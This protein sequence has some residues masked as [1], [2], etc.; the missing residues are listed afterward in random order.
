MEVL[1]TIVVFIITLLVYVHITNQFKKS[2]DMEVYEM[3]Y[4]NEEELQK[5][6][7]L[8]QPFIF[9][10][11]SN[12][13]KIITMEYLQHYEKE[14]VRVK[15]TNDYSGSQSII[16]ETYIPFS[17]F[18]ILMKT[19]TKS[20]YFIENN[21]EFMEE[22]GLNAVID[23][24]L[25]I[26]LNPKY[27]IVVQRKYDICMGSK[28]VELPLRYHTNFRHFYMV[29]HGKIHIKMTPF[30]NSIHLDPVND[31]NIYEN[32]SP[33]NIWK[34]NIENVSFLEFDVLEGQIFYV[35]SYWWYSIKYSN[36]EDTI[37]C[38]CTYHSLTNIVAH[39]PELV[40]YYIHQQN[41]EKKYMK[42][43]DKNSAPVHEDDA[44][45]K[46]EIIE[47]TLD[48]SKPVENDY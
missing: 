30:K 18:Y 5:V 40:K 34:A 44:E 23:K 43:L 37:I 25:N 35:P 42:T 24:E 13:N 32:Y 31:Y 46:E 17:S 27:S 26:F 14:Y 19:D 1:I 21:D 11:T 45:V 12:I 47:T 41:L 36:I 7:E 33:K 16:G 9:T 39:S 22:T 20:H 38:S 29:L 48:V 15:D 4:K 28:N 6:C 2:A 10:I 3:D 8:K